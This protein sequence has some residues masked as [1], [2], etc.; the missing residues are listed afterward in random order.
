M[1]PCSLYNTTQKRRSSAA[2]FLGEPVRRDQ[3]RW[4]G[5]TSGGTLARPPTSCPLRQAAQQSG[6]AG[7]RAIGCWPVLASAI[8]E[9]KK[10]ESALCLCYTSLSPPPP[11]RT[12]PPAHHLRLAATQH[13]AY[14]PCKRPAGRPLRTARRLPSHRSP[15]GLRRRLAQAPPPFPTKRETTT[16]VY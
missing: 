2:Y 8:D 12:R 15:Q 1:R 16:S 5:K 7:L 11:S 6:S 4:S 14:N 13:A 9:Q 10:T 3:H